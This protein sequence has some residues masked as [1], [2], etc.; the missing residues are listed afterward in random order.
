MGRP[1]KVVLI[2]IDGMIPEFVQKFSREGINS[3]GRS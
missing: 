3:K 1:K 2:G